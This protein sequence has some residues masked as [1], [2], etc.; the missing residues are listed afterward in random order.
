MAYHFK[1][2]LELNDKRTLKE[3]GFVQG[4]PIQDLY[5]QRG[6]MTDKELFD[7]E[8]NLVIT[9]N[10]TPSEY[11]KSRV[12]GL[13]NIIR[14]NY[15]EYSTFFRTNAETKHT[16]NNRREIEKYVK[17]MRRREKLL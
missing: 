4:N 10:M 15:M 5:N 14:R 11:F 1:H 16:I 6:N 8:R 3:F 9:H 2:D 13:E 17:R 12:V 7:E